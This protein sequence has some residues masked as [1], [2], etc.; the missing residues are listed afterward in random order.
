MTDSL[1]GIES[2]S[3]DGYIR[4]VEDELI[5]ECQAGLIDAARTLRAAANAAEAA[6]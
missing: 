5:A 4:E 2:D 3:G 1:S 6:A